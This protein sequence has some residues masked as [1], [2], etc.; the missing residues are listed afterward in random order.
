MFFKRACIEISASAWHIWHINR[1]GKIISSE[2]FP[3]PVFKLKISRLTKILLLLNI[4]QTKIKIGEEFSHKNLEDYIFDSNKIGETLFV[5]AL[6][7]DSVNDLLNTC[8]E[9]G[10]YQIHAIDTLEYRMTCYF[11]GLYQEPLWLIIPQKPGIRLIALKDGVPWGCYFFS[12]DPDFREH[13]LIR[14]WLDQQ[15]APQ[16]AVI[17]SDDDAYLWMRGFLDERQVSLADEPDSKQMMI[18]GLRF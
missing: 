1:K 14:I 17:L 18:E 5:S 3:T 16:M 9:K 15:D 13:E 7:K 4:A 12:N 2:K 8:R 6:A 11:G 10:I